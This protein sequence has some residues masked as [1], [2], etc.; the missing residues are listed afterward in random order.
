MP[1]VVRP[2]DANIGPPAERF[3]R[4]VWCCTQPLAGAVTRI[5]DDQF[6]FYST[7]MTERQQ[8][9]EV[10]HG[11]HVA[12]RLY[13]KLAGAHDQRGVIFER[14]RRVHHRR[15]SQELERQWP[16]DQNPAQGTTA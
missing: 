13:T 8:E 2:N 16:I 9:L 6:V 1:Q 15:Q 5:T 12:W 14:E 3:E 10:V 7:F 4:S 11:V